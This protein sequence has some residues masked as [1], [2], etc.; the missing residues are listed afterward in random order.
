[1]R[2]WGS[3]LNH[4]GMSFF[5]TSIPEGTQLYHGRAT[6]ESV[7]GPDWLAFEAEHALAF[8]RPRRNYPPP[9]EYER[10]PPLP[11]GDGLSQ[12]SES[13]A[14]KWA[15]HWPLLRELIHYEG[16][17]EHREGTGNDPLTTEDDLNKYSQQ[18]HFSRP[19][20]RH[21]RAKSSALSADGW[22]DTFDSESRRRRRPVVDAPE[23]EEGRLH[24]Q[25]LLRVEDDDHDLG[26]YLHTYRT[27]QPLSLLY[28]DGMSAGKTTNG[29]LDSTD[30]VLQPFNSS[31]EDPMTGEW[32][33]ASGLCNMSRND[34]KGRV[35]GFVRME[36]GFE[37][38]LCDFERY[39]EIDSIS[40]TSEREGLGKRFGVDLSFY[41]AI[42]SRFD[43]IGGNRVQVDYD[44]FV[45]SFEYDA[46]L[47]EDGAEHPRLVNVSNTTRAAIRKDVT[48]MIL[49][50]EGKTVASGYN[51]QSVADMVVKR[52]SNRLA[53]LSSSSIESLGQMQ[54][55]I[56]DLL[57]PYIDYSSR[58]TSL[59]IDRCAAQY[60]PRSSLITSSRPLAAMAI[61]TVT[62]YLC[63]TLVKATRARSL[64][65]AQ[66]SIQSLVK[67]LRW[68]S[69]KKCSGCEPNEICFIPIWPVGRKQ[70]YEKPT[71]QNS[72][73]HNSNDSYWGGFERSGRRRRSKGTRAREWRAFDEEVRGVGDNPRDEVYGPSS[74]L[75]SWINAW[76][77]ERDHL[78]D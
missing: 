29:T 28:I 13:P 27:K 44:R 37:I 30:Y 61:H 25:E 47:F 58:N 38:I 33:R 2:Q 21:R 22:S 52:Y 12:S 15:G 41:R 36:M 51:W 48:D 16:P 11:I 24:Q 46:D 45:T 1:M 63:D 43:E 68:T 7:K 19:K 42:A 56:Q 34:W 49:S 78:L 65:S 57:T 17:P 67:Y 31:V 50:H 39:L 53:Y 35:D 6:N 3:S 9:E 18:Q 59:E 64:E 26:G 5:I 8:A 62:S 14:P 55:E 10:R 66:R 69:W 70:D 32:G 54:A 23:V 72:V 4:N 77:E 76:P 74:Y 20:K 40:R 73:P 75:G 60:I 71:C